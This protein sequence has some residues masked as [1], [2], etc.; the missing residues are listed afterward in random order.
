MV[1][2]QCSRIVTKFTLQDSANGMDLKELETNETEGLR[3]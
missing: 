1:A 3:Q 2:I